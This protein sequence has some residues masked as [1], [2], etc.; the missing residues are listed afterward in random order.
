MPHRHALAHT[1]SQEGVGARYSKH[2]PLAQAP[3][4]FGRERAAALSSISASHG[5]ALVGRCSVCGAA[6]HLRGGPA[7]APSSLQAV[8]SGWSRECDFVGLQVL[9]YKLAYSPRDGLC[10]GASGGAVEL[11]LDT[12]QVHR[13]P[14]LVSPQRLPRVKVQAISRGGLGQSLGLRLEAAEWSC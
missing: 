10:S 3:P 14:R 7:R 8:A 2:T 6:L 12:K 4:L 13:C 1:S 11:E 5:S 9:A